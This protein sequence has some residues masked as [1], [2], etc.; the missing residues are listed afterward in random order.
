[1]NHFELPRY[2]K[3]K[4]IFTPL[5]QNEMYSTSRELEDYMDDIISY[6]LSGDCHTPNPT[7]STRITIE[8]SRFFSPGNSALEHNITPLRLV[9]ATLPVSGMF[10]MSDSPCF[11][12]SYTL[13]GSGN[14]YV[15]G[16]DFYFRKGHAGFFNC[17]HHIEFLTDPTAEC[18]CI[19]LYVCG[20][21]VEEYYQYLEQQHLLYRMM[22]TY[23]RFNQLLSELLRDSKHPSSGNNMLF[24]TYILGLISEMFMYTQQAMPASSNIPKY[25]TDAQ[26]YIQEHYSEPIS[27]EIL[28]RHVHISKYH[29]SHEF[30]KH[31]NMSPNE[32]LIRLRMDRAKDLLTSTDKTIEE[33]S[34]SIG[35]IN[36]NHFR[37]L[38]QKHENMPPTSFRKRWSKI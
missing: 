18:R 35:I 14:I 9:V 24:S 27:L 21:I 10:I 19:F 17:Q 16:K 1:M 33:I 3:E 12:I 26:D 38:F 36:A 20:T 32:Y 23:S 2:I 5:L 13:S 15:N 34:L 8:T 4:N 29:L 7:D 31:L 28:A 30:K 11:F 6:A 22:P 25:V 37:Y